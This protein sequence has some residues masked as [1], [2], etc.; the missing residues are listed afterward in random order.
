MAENLS[1]WRHEMQTRQLLD[2]LRQANQKFGPRRFTLSVARDGIMLPMVKSSKY[3]E[4]STATI[5]VL[6]RWGPRLGTVY[7]GQM[8]EVGQTSLSQELTAL[9]LAVL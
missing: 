6:D 1:A 7:L 8:P 3:K 2:W 5:S 9:L 4:A